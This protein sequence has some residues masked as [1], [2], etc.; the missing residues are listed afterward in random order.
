MHLF[1]AMVQ[2]TVSAA[3]FV[4]KRY[5]MGHYM[6]QRIGRWGV[7]DN[8][9]QRLTTV[10]CFSGYSSFHTK[11]LVTR[12]NWTIADLSCVSHCRIIQIQIQICD[13]HKHNYNNW[14]GSSSQI[15]GC[16]DRLTYMVYLETPRTGIELAKPALV[17]FVDV[18][19]T[20]IGK[21]PKWSYSSCLWI[22]NTII[23]HYYE[24]WIISFLRVRQLLM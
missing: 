20:I 23:W 11:W 13:W 12:Y 3:H 4:T 18:K 15:L 9:C 21:G 5:G 2:P 8:N 22:E 10:E 24:Y 7:P 14:W 19:I 6:K 17:A 16:G 1:L